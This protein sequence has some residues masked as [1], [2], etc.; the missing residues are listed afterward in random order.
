MELSIRLQVQRTPFWAIQNV[1]LVIPDSNVIN[2]IIIDHTIFKLLGL[3]NKAILNSI[4][5]GSSKFD[6]RSDGA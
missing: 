1:N 5:D 6:T 2:H 4:N 3:D